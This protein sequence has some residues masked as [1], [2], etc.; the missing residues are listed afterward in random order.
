MKNISDNP[1]LDALFK[2]MLLSASIHMLILFFFAAKAHQYELL[3]YFNIL[4][5]DFF[6]PNIAKGYVSMLLATL[7]VV[8]VYL[9]FFVRRN[10]KD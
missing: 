6:F 3:N 9:Y 4:D 5:L 8:V 7:T 1:F 10:K 2:T